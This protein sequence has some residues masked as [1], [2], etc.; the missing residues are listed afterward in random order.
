MRSRRVKP[1]R[2]AAACNCPSPQLVG[3]TLF[4]IVYLTIQHQISPY[5]HVSDNFVAL[6]SSFSL[7]VLFFCCVILKVTTA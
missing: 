5:L 2:E 7:A 4:S 1:P 3:A 6:A